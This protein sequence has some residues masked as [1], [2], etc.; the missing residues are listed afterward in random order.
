MAQKKILVSTS[1][2]GKADAAPLHLLREN[3]DVELN[4]FGRKLTTEEFISL[5]KDVVGVIAGVETITAEA[6]LMRPNIKVIS[7][8]G[9]GL[10]SV[11]LA[12]CETM[13]IKVYNTPLAPVDSVAELTVALML[14]LLKNVSRMDTKLKAGQWE[15]MTGLMLRGKQVGIIGMGRIGTRVAKLLEAFSV[16]LTYT[17]FRY[18]KNGYTFLPLDELL[19]QSDIVTLHAT[20]SNNQ[21]II[22]PQEIDKMKDGAYLINTARGKSVDEAALIDGLQ[23][24]KLVGAALDVFPKEP[25]T[26][27]LCHMENVILT[28]HVASSAKES[29]VTM[30][31]E[32]AKNLIA[33]LGA[34]G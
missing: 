31:L 21:P 16:K 33:G 11:D 26:G 12:T 20:P 6:L 14:N 28:P 2:F 27:E 17:D 7:R 22:G 4:P 19:K 1:S 5:T 18:M 30:E 13:G 3:F 24:G 9:V 34:Y 23:C 10:D 25:Y 29:R 8:C 32:A 15:K